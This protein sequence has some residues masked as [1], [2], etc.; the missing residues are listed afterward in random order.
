MLCDQG[1]YAAD[2]HE[3]N[4]FTVLSF[5]GHV[6]GW[7]GGAEGGGVNHIGISVLRASVKQIGTAEST[8]AA[9]CNGGQR[10]AEGE[11]RV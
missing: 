3:A 9:S 8:L 2:P 10:R 11:A 6:W 5:R 1:T 7:S 4:L